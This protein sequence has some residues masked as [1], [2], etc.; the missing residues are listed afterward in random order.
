[1]KQR[2][3]KFRQPIFNQKGD[4]LKWHYWGIIGKGKFIGP[5]GCGDNSQQYTGLKDK[6]GKEIYEGDLIGEKNCY[7]EVIFKDGKFA[8]NTDFEPIIEWIWGRER[9][10]LE[11]EVIGNIY[12][13]SNLLK[14]D[15]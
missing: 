1:M 6:N 12:E 15:K 5:I 2:E 7:A 3:I 13:N 9:K 4:F 14:N 11:T 10:R 8:N